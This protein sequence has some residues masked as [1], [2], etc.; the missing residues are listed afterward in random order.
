VLASD[1]PGTRELARHFPNLRLMSLQEDDEA[2][3]V[4]AERLINTR[5]PATADAAERLARTPFAF[6][7]SCEAHYE[8][9]SRPHA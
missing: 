1:L 7:R 6:E 4:A 2:W 5:P 3:A 9:W 8:M